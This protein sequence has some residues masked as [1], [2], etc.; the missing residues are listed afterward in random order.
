ML[1]YGPATFLVTSLP[2][3]FT[4]VIDDWNELINQWYFD[5]RLFLSGQSF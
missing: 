4:E 5:L 1:E 2:T 3:Y